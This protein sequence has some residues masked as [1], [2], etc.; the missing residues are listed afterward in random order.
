[1]DGLKE[2]AQGLQEQWDNRDPNAD[3][4]ALEASLQEANTNRDTAQG[5]FDTEFAKI[6]PLQEAYDEAKNT[7][8]EAWEEWKVTHIDT[9]LW[10][11]P[12]VEAVEAVEGQDAQYDDDGVETS[13]AVEAVEAVEAQ[14]AVE[15]VVDKYRKIDKQLNDA[16][17]A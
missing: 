14:D 3:N 6:A 15:G 13:P 17:I 11:R 10:G 16:Y 4:S 1:M 2:T 9:I 12:A 7:S 5:E 8:D